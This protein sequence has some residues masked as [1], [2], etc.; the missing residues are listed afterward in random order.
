MKTLRYILFMLLSVTA[1]IKA[2][3]QLTPMP[4]SL[5]EKEAV[6]ALYF[7]DTKLSASNTFGFSY[8]NHTQNE[9]SVS[10]FIEYRHAHNKA[11]MDDEFIEQWY[12]MMPAGTKKSFEI[13]CG[14][15]ETNV[16]TYCKLCYCVDAGCHP[17][18]G[19]W[20]IKGRR[21][22]KK[23]AYRDQSRLKKLYFHCHPRKIRE[24]SKVNHKS[25]KG[26]DT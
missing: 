12:F 15:L 24:F 26:H 1:G 3:A 8:I 2:Q 5:I 22:G 16:V 7:E 18:D 11:I 20:G 4:D 14:S 19:D 13:V 6:K 23:M 17:A 25:R 9:G 10:F 21:K